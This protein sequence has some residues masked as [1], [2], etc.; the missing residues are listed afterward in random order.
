ML[1]GTK[2]TRKNGRTYVKQ[3]NGKWKVERKHELHEFIKEHI[4]HHEYSPEAEEHSKG[5]M[6]EMLHEELNNMHEG[7]KRATRGQR[8]HLAQTEEHQ[9]MQGKVVGQKSTFPKWFKEAGAHST[10]D[11]ARA[12]ENKK[13]KLYK[14]LLEYAHHR[15]LNGYE[16]NDTYDFGHPLYIGHAAQAGVIEKHHAMKRLSEIDQ[17]EA[18]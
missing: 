15:L 5:K 12:I 2:V 3:E 14:R 6:M 7:V 9:G 10:K 18:A 1:V 13:G 4:K 16:D 17:R 11:V 8:V